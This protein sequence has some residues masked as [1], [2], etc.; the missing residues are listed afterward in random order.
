[1]VLLSLLKQFSLKIKT[2][3]MRTERNFILYNR[4][5]CNL[6]YCNTLYNC[7]SFCSTLTSYYCVFMFDIWYASVLTVSDS[8]S[9]PSVPFCKGINSFSFVN[10][11]ETFSPCL[12]LKHE[13]PNCMN[14]GETGQ[15]RHS[16]TRLI[17]LVT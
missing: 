1:M 14:D 8:R 4:D 9:Q 7:I 17:Y 5:I 16:L 15:N 2:F 12:V 13:L 11:V 10:L 3:Y 6:T